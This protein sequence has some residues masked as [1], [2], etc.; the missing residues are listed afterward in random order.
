MKRNA[1]LN[2]VQRSFRVEGQR[3]LGQK[4]RPELIGPVLSDLHGSLQDAVRMGFLHSSR[5]R[6]RI[7]MSLKDAA[8]V[9][10]I[11]HE[12]SG[13][14][15]TVLHFELPSFGSAAPGFFEQP[16]LWEDGPHPEETAFELFGAALIDVAARKGDSSRYDPPLLGRISRYGRMLKRGIDRVSLVGSGLTETGRI[17]AAVVHA[18]SHLA[19]ATPSP[20]RARVVGRLDLMG[21]SQGV[22]KIEVS[23]GQVVTVLWEGDEP[24]DHY[25]ELFNRDVVVEGLAIFRPSG[26]LLR[27]DADV[28]A[29]ASMQEDFF[30]QIPHAAVARDYQ[31]MARLKPNEPSAYAQLRGCMPAEA[32]DSD[33]DFQAAIAALR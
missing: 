26:S 20:Q 32:G 12:G 8:D 31:K 25:R 30:R 23:S 22:L 15:L 4:P 24:L 5:P 19:A 1:A 16:M 33:E 2:V 17:D 18:A 10:F 6:G 29:A 11:G 9:R 27:L 7:R 14:D 3:G 21:K 13:N 28:I